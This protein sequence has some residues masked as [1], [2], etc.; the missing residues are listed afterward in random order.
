MKNFIKDKDHKYFFKHCND[1]INK[2]AE[3]PFFDDIY[4]YYKEFADN[5]TAYLEQVTDYIIEKMSLELSDSER[6]NL[7]T[8]AYYCGSYLG[9]I[10]KNEKIKRFNDEGFYIIKS[11]EKLD[12]RKIEFIVDCS[13]E[14]FGGINKFKGKLV[15]AQVDKRLMAM[16]P[17]CTR[18]GVWVD[19]CDNNVYVKL[20]KNK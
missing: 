20:L 7:K 5:G 16:K 12:G 8:Y 15:W 6:S 10:K 4:K 11:D 14:M 19:N 3:L 2:L 9:N 13:G 17:R 1:D 18:K